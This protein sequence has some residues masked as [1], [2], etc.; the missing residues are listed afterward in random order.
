MDC[1]VFWEMKISPQVS[2]LAVQSPAR[3][4]REVPL[5][6]NLT[7]MTLKLAHLKGDQKGLLIGKEH[8]IK[9]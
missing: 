2:E 7:L 5:N 9:V 8:K 4:S 1:A 3:M 6:R